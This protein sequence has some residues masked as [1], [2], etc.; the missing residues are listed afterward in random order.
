[1][2]LNLYLKTDKF[3]NNMGMLMYFRDELSKLGYKLGSPVD[4]DCMCSIECIIDNEVITLFM[5]KNDEE[6]SPPIWQIWPEQN[7]SILKKLFSKADKAPEVKAKAL[8]EQI[9]QGIAGVD[10]VEWAI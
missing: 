4:E 2:S 3:K 10:G 5:G 8:I 7:V 1:M 9:A 6:S